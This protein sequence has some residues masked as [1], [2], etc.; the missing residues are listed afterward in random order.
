MWLWWRSGEPVTN[1]CKKSG[2]F[3]DSDFTMRSHVRNT[4][5]SCFSILRQIRSVSRSLPII[6]RKILVTSLVLPR[7]DYCNSV[8][9]GLPA[10]QLHRLQL[11]INAAAKMISNAKK[12]DHVTPILHDLHWLRLPERIAFKVALLVFKCLHDNG[13]LYLSW[14]LQPTGSVAGRRRLRSSSSGHLVVPASRRA[15]LGDRCFRVIGPRTW[16][17]LPSAIRLA[18]S[19]AEFC[20]LLKSFLFTV[21]YSSHP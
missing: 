19:E 17:G 13:P 21:S 16:N 5:R 12:Y 8:L 9:V 20:G 1:A 3:I 6:G 18:T 2:V 15:L 10:S 14:D 11:V 4:V 7:I